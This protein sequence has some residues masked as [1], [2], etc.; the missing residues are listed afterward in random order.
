[1]KVNVRNNHNNH[2]ATDGGGPSDLS[3]LDEQ[4]AESCH[5]SLLSVFCFSPS[6]N[7]Y[8]GAFKYHPFSSGGVRVERQQFLVP[9]HA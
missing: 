6:T 9:S 3:P 7:S 2:G 5:L 1:M 4:R 8:T